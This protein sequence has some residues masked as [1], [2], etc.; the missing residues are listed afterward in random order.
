MLSA[1][2]LDRRRLLKLATATAAGLGWPRW[3]SSIPR[4]SG[5]PF[6]LGVAS[7]CPT[8]D[9]VVLWTRLSLPTPDPRGAPTVGWELAH[10]EAFRRGVR[11]GRTLAPAELGH[12]V[13]VEVAGLDPDRW[14]FY[15][16]FHG[17]AVSPIGRTRSFP[18][19]AAGVTRLR[20]AFASCQRWE[21]GY[22]AAYRHMR[23]D[24]PDAVVFLGDYIYEYPGSGNPIRPAPG[25]WAVSLEDYRARYALYK[26]DPDLQAMHAACPW[27]PIWDDHEVQNDYAGLHSGE[28][29]PPGTV[30]DF[31]ARRAAAY[32]AYYEHMPVPAASLVRS[33]AGLFDPRRG[34]ALRI[35]RRLDFGRLASIYLLDDRQY[36]DPHAC[37]E[38]G[39][40]G[41]RSLDPADC[42][43]WTAPGRSMLGAEQE[44][45]LEQAFSQGSPGWNV[46][47]QQTLFGQMDRRPGPGQILWS[48]GWDGYGAARRRLTDSLQR[49]AVANPVILGGDVHQNWVGHVKADYAVPESPAVGVE[50]CGTS[51]SSRAAPSAQV[52]ERLAE[53]PHYV[54]ANAQRRGYGLAEFT[55]RKLRVSLRVVDD[56]TRPD[57]SVE[58]LARF[59]VE[60]GRPVLEEG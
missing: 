38:E 58:T 57:A 27:L 36:R 3:T 20:L 23:A 7:G 50:F 34:G 19:A 6:A 40:A 14:Y 48:D 15:R 42:P 33:L 9:S 46:L 12:A 32:Q 22:F 5:D 13:H 53:N 60:A 17:E 4:L 8:A 30:V 1:P 37:T 25:R 18:A 24:D 43:V 11:R 2:G 31:L 47:A 45:W 29:G 49:H 59:A 41:S 56:A 35:Y 39:S 28:S 51:I 16:F 52:A 54:F 55:P 21:H 44:Q 26:S 10:D